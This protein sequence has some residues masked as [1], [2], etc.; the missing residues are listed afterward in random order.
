MM[1]EILE[2]L[3]RAIEKIDRAIIMIQEN[4]DLFSG[5]DLDILLA[6]LKSFREMRDIGMQ[7]KT[8]IHV[9]K[10]E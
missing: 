6:S 3:N 9:L 7:L 8:D 2:K 10:G 5:K 1:T 4:V